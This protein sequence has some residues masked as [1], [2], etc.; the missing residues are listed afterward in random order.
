MKK[1]NYY[2]LLFLIF[3]MIF[4]LV[5]FSHGK[6]F[7]ERET[8]LYVSKLGDNSDGSSWQKAFN[9]VQAALDA[10][11]DS[12]GG[13]TIV[14]RPDTYFEAMLYPKFRGAKGKYNKLLGDVDGSYGG[15]TTG[16]V[17]I[18][19]GDPR[20]K[21]FKSYDWWGPIRSNMK[22]WSKAHTDSTFSAIG[23]D[24]WHLKNLYVTGGDG[25]IFFDLTDQVKPFSVIVE[26]CVSIG[27]AFG[28]GVANCL[29]RADE[30]IIFC[31]SYLWALDE[32]GDTA[33]A[34]V[35]IENKKMPEQ[36]DIIFENCTMV[37]PQCAFKSSNYGFYTYTHAALKNCRLIV[38]NF[39]QPQ[40]T[41][42]NGIIQSVQ[43][44]KLLHIDLENCTL[45]GYKVFGVLVDKG[46]VSDISYTAK[47]DVKA[48]VQFQ[49]SI[50]KGFHRLGHWPADIFQTLLPPAPQRLMPPL[51]KKEFLSRDMVEVTP[52]IWKGELC[53]LE[54]HRPGSGGTKEDYFITLKN[55]TTGKE[56]ARFAVGYSLASAF[57]Y[58]DKFYVFA[59]RFENNNW[60]DVT[61]FYSPDLKKWSRKVIVKQNKNEHLFNSS[62][63]RGKDGFVLAYESNDPSYSPFTVKFARSK[64]LQ[65]WDKL[66]DALLGT[67]RYAACPAIRY[68]DG[69]YYVLYLERRS[70]RHYF[71][72]WIARSPDLKQ[73]ELSSANPVLYPEG[74]DEGVNAS[75]P[76]LIEWQG[77]TLLFYSVGDQ[78][79]WMN[80]KYNQYA[81][82]LKDYLQWWFKNPG[83]KY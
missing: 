43:E 57:V 24:R 16:R 4:V 68:T 33:G 40:G 83:I 74:T 9:S 32:W 22:G 49:Q 8:R 58:D 48:Y 6:T 14:I 78:L 28:G 47:G 44:G 23:W 13:Y 17:I 69:Y 3:S 62:V 42:S 72:T 55:F 66:P 79:T 67:K 38:L 30:P 80:L 77:K 15:G 25:G 81:M 35:R 18:D 52:V 7:P 41:P 10:V 56:L 37:S 71:E 82:P 2:P 21:G 29:S 46:T 61:L 64:D 1:Q 60:N 36:P 27:R 59:S 76:D 73:W 53:L 5:S 65:N 12:R 19:S 20:Q 63:C 50:P 31:G 45:M 39:S 54:C 75:D 70:P 51:E 11:P 26:N 34:Y